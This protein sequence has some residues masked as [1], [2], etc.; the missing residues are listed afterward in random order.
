MTIT[1]VMANRK[2]HADGGD[3]EHQRVHL[4]RE[5]GSLF[6]IKWQ[7][8]LQRLSE[9]LDPD[10]WKAAGANCGPPPKFRGGAK[11]KFLRQCTE[12]SVTPPRRT[13]LRI[14]AL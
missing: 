10:R 6:R 2:E 4:R 5:V 3:E 11:S 7:L 9:L 14:E 13:I 1:A 8:R 12:S